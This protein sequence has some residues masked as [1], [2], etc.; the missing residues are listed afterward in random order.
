[1]TGDENKIIRGRFPPLKQNVEKKSD[2]ERFVRSFLK[3]FS[4]DTV[5]IM[6]ATLPQEETDFTA[7]FGRD[8]GHWIEICKDVLQAADQGVLEAAAIDL[9]PAHSLEGAHKALQSQIRVFLSVIHNGVP[10]LIL[11]L[12]PDKQTYWE[13][14]I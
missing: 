5:R 13:T 12:S 9:G 7:Q 2:A 3:N 14:P 4:D 10:K 6:S 8:M 11:A 1:M